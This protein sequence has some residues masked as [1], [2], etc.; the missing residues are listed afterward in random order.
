MVASTTRGRVDDDGAC[1]DITYRLI[2]AALEVHRTLG[3]GFKEGVYQEALAI[4]CEARGIRWEAWPAVRVHYKGRLLKTSYVPD[5][6]IEDQVLVEIKAADVITDRDRAQLLGYVR[7]T[8]RP[9]GLL[10]NF[11]AAQLKDGIE[12]VVGQP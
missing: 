6:L 12:R 10:L 9:V 11:G 1:A 5:F 8:G 3:P 2:G 7:V 4:E